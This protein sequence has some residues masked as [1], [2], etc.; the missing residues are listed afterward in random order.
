MYHRRTRFYIQAIVAHQLASFLP[1]GPLKRRTSAARFVRCTNIAFVQ[2]L[3]GRI[4]SNNMEKE[5]K[6]SIQYGS[7]EKTH[8][9]T[10]ESSEFLTHT[11]AEPQNIY[12][13]MC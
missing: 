6:Y 4:F 10:E 3:K 1:G 12:E 7:L 2:R 11:S 5:R 13:I 9:G 8:G